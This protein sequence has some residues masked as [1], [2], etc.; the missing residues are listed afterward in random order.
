MKT[1]LS[2]DLELDRGDVIEVGVVL[3]SQGSPPDSWVRKSWLVKPRHGL[4]LDPHITTLTGITQDMINSQGV[5]HAR[6][7][8]ELTELIELHRPFTNP[9]QWGLGDAQELLAELDDMTG[10]APPI[11]GRRVIDVKHHYLFVEAACG[12]S[13]SGGL[14]RAMARHGLEFIGRPHRATDDA[15]NTL[16]FYFHLLHRQSVIE[17]YIKCMKNTFKV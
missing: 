6:V 11:F 15:F 7:K 14:R 16:R 13:L 1:Y 4:P 2:L 5:E 10:S 12:R 9:V 8:G 3:G 17:E